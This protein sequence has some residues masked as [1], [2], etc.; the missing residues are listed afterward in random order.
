MLLLL[1]F[2]FVWHFMQFF[3]LPP[4][5]ILFLS[6]SRDEPTQLAAL[7]LVQRMVQHQTLKQEYTAAIMPLIF[8]FG[9]HSSEDC[10]ALMYEV[11]IT[12]YSNL[13]WAKIS[14]EYNKGV[15][16]IIAKTIAR[17]RAKNTW[18]R[19]RVIVREDLN[20]IILNE[21]ISVCLGPIVYYL[22][23]VVLMLYVYVECIRAEKRKERV[24]LEKRWGPW[25]RAWGTSY[26]WD[27]QM[28]QKP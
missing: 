24:Q 2:Y 20:N 1:L 6:H 10:R 22:C 14:T 12:A 26:S 8:K 18:T 11:L 25:W 28:T 5:Y 15:A 16:R 9:E 7:K 19:A 23:Q 27:C 4:L 21:D 17:V 13:V 3:F